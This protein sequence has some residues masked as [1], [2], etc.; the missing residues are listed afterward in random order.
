M[1][2]VYEVR[3]RVSAPS[4]HDLDERDVREL[5]IGDTPLRVDD[6]KVSIIDTDQPEGA[7]V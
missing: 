6:C 1:R 7:P 4:E 3:L 2:H 5:L